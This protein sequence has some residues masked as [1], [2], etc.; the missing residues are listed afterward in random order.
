M[1]TTNLQSKLAIAGML[2][3]AILSPARAD[4]L[5]STFAGTYVFDAGN[6]TTRGGSDG[7]VGQA[8]AFEPDTLDT[9]VYNTVLFSADAYSSAN[10]G[11]GEL[12]VY[13]SSTGPAV[14]SAIARFSDII[15][16]VPTAGFQNL[17]DATFTLTVDGNL[18]GNAGGGGELQVGSTVQ[19]VDVGGTSIC[20]ASPAECS[21]LPSTPGGAVVQTLIATVAVDPAN[22]TVFI[23][24]SL[25]AGANEFGNFRLGEPGTAD[26]SDTAH[27][28]ITL[29]EGFTFTSNS[30]LLLTEV[31]S[32]SGVPEPHLL[33]LAAAAGVLLVGLA[34]RGRAQS[35]SGGVD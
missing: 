34:R 30:G 29:P 3:F 12:K 21:P 5:Y 8:T 35:N 18:T 4:I 7:G 15:T 10:L 19:N 25:F 6:L 22:P 1:R 11:A 32:T 20:S 17:F 23:T 13:A 14:A 16:I 24:P 33:A 28:S 27:L 9:G 2:T 26:F 31:P